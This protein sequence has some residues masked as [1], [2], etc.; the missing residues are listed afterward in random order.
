M[1]DALKNVIIDLARLN[2][3]D[4]CVRSLRSSNQWIIITLCFP[5]A[6]AERGRI[7][8]DDLDNWYLPV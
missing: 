5:M 2:L 6:Q 3:S 1:D 4:A 7:E 8:P